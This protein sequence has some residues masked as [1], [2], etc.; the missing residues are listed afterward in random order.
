MTNKNTNKKRREVIKLSASFLIALI[1]FA[2]CKKEVTTIGADI[3]PNGLNIVQQDTF[4]VV[5]STVVADSL[6]TNN[7]SVSLLGGLNDPEVGTV[8]CGIVTQV[9]LSS[10]SP[11]FGTIADITVDSVVLSFLYSSKLFYGNLTNLTFE[12]YE[13]DDQLDKETDYFAH[14]AVT[15]KGSNLVIPGTETQEPSPYADVIVGSDTVAPMLR[16]NL[17]TAFGDYLIQ[18]ASEMNTNDNFVSFFKGLYIKVANTNSFGPNK[19]TILYFALESALSNMV[20][21]YTIGGENKRFTFNINNN[22]ARFN[23]IDFNY[24]GTPLEASINNPETAQEKIYLQ[25][26]HLRPEFSFPHITSLMDGNRV[27]NRAELIVPVQN[28]TSS[29]FKPS[30]SLFLGRVKTSLQTDLTYDYSNFTTVGLDADENVFRFNLTRDLQRVISG[31][32]ENVPYRI[33]PTN[34]FGS[35]I[36]RTIFSG[37]N[38][39]AKDKT[40]LVITYT[41][42]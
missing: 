35:T 10:E 40:K 17:T 33:Y 5:T 24:N 13:I 7:T 18:N 27:I 16:L 30:N 37:P 3:N 14:T 12:V 28:F 6:P 1:V 20:L 22:C 41:E 9:R 29:P 11:N 32:I 23:K 8:D 25:G 21:Y 34:F 26:S 15:T 42:Y 4:T 36:E 31:E 38:S 39:I 2:S 19:G